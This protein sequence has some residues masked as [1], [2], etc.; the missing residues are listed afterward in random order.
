MRFLFQGAHESENDGMPCVAD[1]I[2]AIKATAKYLLFTTLIFMRTRNGYIYC[3]YLFKHIRMVHTKALAYACQINSLGQI[4]CK[5]KTWNFNSN[6]ML[7]INFRLIETNWILFC[8][9]S[10][11][12]CLLHSNA[13]VHHRSDPFCVSKFQSGPNGNCASPLKQ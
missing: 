8:M 1:M 9:M 11:F 3:I 13:N 6:W 2:K 4:S 10:V 12:F 5:S 7:F